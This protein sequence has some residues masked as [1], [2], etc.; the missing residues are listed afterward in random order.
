MTDRPRT[1]LGWILGSDQDA[2]KLIQR[3]GLEKPLLRIVHALNRLLT[4]K[5]R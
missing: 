5:R 1:L 3:L 2:Y 4:R